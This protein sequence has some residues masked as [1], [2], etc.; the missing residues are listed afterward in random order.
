MTMTDQPQ[1]VTDQPLPV[2]ALAQPVYA[3]PQ[4]EYAQPYKNP[5]QGGAPQQGGPP[6][7]WEEETDHFQHLLCFCLFGGYDCRPFCKN[8]V[9]N[10]HRLNHLTSRFSFLPIHLIASGFRAGLGPAVFL[11]S[12]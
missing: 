12:A 1:P 11:D 4:P 5:Q 2:T 8:A 7:K 3:Q 6:R 9:I 10:F